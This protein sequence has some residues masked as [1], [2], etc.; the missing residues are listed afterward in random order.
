MNDISTFRNIF[1]KLTLTEGGEL[2]GL[3]LHGNIDPLLKVYIFNIT[4]KDDF[5][6]GK[7][8][9]RLQEVGPYIYR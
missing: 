6:Q 1:Q 7:E 3:W 9:L 8:K 2:F 4:N 5:L